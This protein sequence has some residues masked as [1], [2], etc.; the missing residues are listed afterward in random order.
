M[1]RHTYIYRPIWRCCRCIVSAKF[2]RYISAIFAHKAATLLFCTECSET[3]TATLSLI[4]ANPVSCYLGGDPPTTWGSTLSFRPPCNRSDKVVYDLTFAHSF[5]RGKLMTVTA[6]DETRV[7]AV[8]VDCFRDPGLRRIR[9]C[10]V[11]HRSEVIVSW[12]FAVSRALL[13]NHLWN[14]SAG[15]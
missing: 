1:Y 5:L 14:L 12:M 3:Q 8:V 10:T 13:C 6:C 9:C 4:N 2:R 7:L 11:L 15:T